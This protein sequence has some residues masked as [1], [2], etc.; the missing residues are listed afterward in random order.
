MVRKGDHI[1]VIE[2]NDLDTLS[3]GLNSLIFSTGSRVLIYPTQLIKTRLQT[4]SGEN[5]YNGFFDAT[6]KIAKQEGIKGYYRGLGLNLL[7]VPLTPIY[8]TVFESSKYLQR[9]FFPS[10]NTELQYFTS[11]FVA[12]ATTQ[13]VGTPVDIVTQYQQV[14]DA[15]NV[16]QNKNITAK[17]SFAIFRQLYQND[18]LIN[19]FY[20]GYSVGTI[21][22]SIHS[23]L[24]WAFYYRSLE[25]FGQLLQDMQLLTRD[26]NAESFKLSN[27]LHVVL[28]GMV[29][30][31]AVNMLTLPLDT[32]RI[33]H[34]LQLERTKGMGI[35]K[36]VFTTSREFYQA[37]GFSGFLRGWSPRLVQAVTTSWIMILG[38]EYLKFISQKRVPEKL[39]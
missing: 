34:Q 26:E 21:T 5:K 37:E 28:S 9:K 20:R 19:G 6:K 27:V 25:F 8:L 1:D 14:T 32:L 13:V 11:G 7:Q 3:F 39:K 36:S 35:K 33:R 22:F 30:S 10:M 2:W 15:K 17:K 24:Y 31:V 29:T 12:S 18:G 16:K 4:Q 38:Y 23:G